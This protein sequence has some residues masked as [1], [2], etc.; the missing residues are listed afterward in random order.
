MSIGGFAFILAFIFVIIALIIMGVVYNTVAPKKR[1]NFLIQE[2]DK[3]LT[4]RQSILGEELIGYCKNIL[5]Q[6][7]SESSMEFQF[8]LNYIYGPYVIDVSWYP[9]TGVFTFRNSS[10]FEKIAV[11]S[12]PDGQPL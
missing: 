12:Y 5:K 8:H 6:I 7:E 4:S 10:T 9:F 11:I 1:K 2:M 3:C